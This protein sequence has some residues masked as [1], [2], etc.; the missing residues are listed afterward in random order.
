M[1][2]DL[3]IDDGYPD[4]TT[5]VLTCARAEKGD[6]ATSITEVGTRNPTTGLERDGSN[7]P[8][9]TIVDGMPTSS[10]GK[11]QVAVHMRWHVPLQG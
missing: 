2:I 9:I 4:P 6:Y 5:P 3:S 10:G 7:F 1:M 8:T 11:R